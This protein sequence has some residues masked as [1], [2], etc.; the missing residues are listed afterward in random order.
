MPIY[1]VSW[2]A[3][4]MVGALMLDYG[5]GGLIVSA[6]DKAAAEARGHE[7][8]LRVYPREQ[9]WN[10]FGVVL[11]EVSTVDIGKLLLSAMSEKKE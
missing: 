1:N 10:K 9:G 8:A 2:I 7:D 5:Y 11:V 3:F 4:K 6:V